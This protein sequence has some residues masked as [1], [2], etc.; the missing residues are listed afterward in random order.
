[1]LIIFFSTFA[2]RDFGNKKSKAKVENIDLINFLLF[3]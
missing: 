1:L 3:I 2:S